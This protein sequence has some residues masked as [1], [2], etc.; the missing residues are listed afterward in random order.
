MSRAESLFSG[1]QA[2]CQGNALNCMTTAAVAAQL[3]AANGRTLDDV[4]AEIEQAIKERKARR[5]AG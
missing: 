5:H 3:P 2:A 1:A 4:R